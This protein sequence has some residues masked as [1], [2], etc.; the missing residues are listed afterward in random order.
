M[1]PDGQRMMCA[2]KDILEGCPAGQQEAAR[3][4][5]QEQSVPVITEA[6]VTRVGLTESQPAS[7]SQPARKDVTLKT[8]TTDKQACHTAAPAAHCRYASRQADSLEH[9]PTSWAFWLVGAQKCFTFV[10]GLQ[11]A[12]ELSRALILC[13]RWP[14]KDYVLPAGTAGRSGALDSG[15]QPCLQGGSR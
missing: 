7:T 1:C 9:V 2:G 5:L 13:S 4:S 14:C 12:T 8:P 10:Q 6:L 11:F 3:K 15:Q